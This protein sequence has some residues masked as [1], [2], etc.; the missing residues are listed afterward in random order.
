[1]SESLGPLE[2]YVGNWSSEYVGENRAPDPDRNV[3]ETKFKQTIHFERILEVENHEQIINGLRYKT[4]AWEEGTDDPFHEEVGYYL[5]DEERSM[6]M[7]CF[8]IPR[9]VSVLAGG[10]ADKESK[11]FTLLAKAGDEEFGIS[12]NPF[13]NKEFKTVVYDLSM[14]Q[15]D[16]NTYSYDENSQLKMKGRE[17]LFDHTENIVMTRC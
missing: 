1:M 13:L 10:K 7:K 4:T 6:I 8:C 11:E 2:F 16:K 15:I 14:K 3:E 17:D 9:G 5:W 12:S